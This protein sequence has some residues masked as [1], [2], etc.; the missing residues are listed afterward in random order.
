MPLCTVCPDLPLSPSRASG[1]APWALPS[2]EE[3]EL[4]SDCGLSWGMDLDDTG[5]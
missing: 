2:P 4:I 3:K 5:S 1:L